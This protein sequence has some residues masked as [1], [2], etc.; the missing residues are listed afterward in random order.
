[1]S[2]VCSGGLAVIVV[3]SET[4]QGSDAGGV[5]TLPTPS[6]AF[7]VKTCAPMPLA[8][9]GCGEVQAAN[10]P[11]SSEHWNVAGS[12]APKLKVAVRSP[13]TRG[14]IEIVVC[15]GVASTVQLNETTAP[16]FPNASVGC[17][18]KMCVPLVRFA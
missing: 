8:V 18:L 17:T 1:M 6:V 2:F 7:T 13:V 5:S 11:L 14:P 16:T 15:G 3:S 4:V 9:T 10:G 12:L